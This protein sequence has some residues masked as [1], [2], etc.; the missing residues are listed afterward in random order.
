MGGRSSSLELAAK[1]FPTIEQDEDA[2]RAP[3]RIAVG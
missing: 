1:T 2:E 3:S